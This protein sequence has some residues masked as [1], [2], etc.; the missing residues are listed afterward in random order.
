MT[1]WMRARER[2]PSR[3]TVAFAKTSDAPVILSHGQLTPDVRRHPR[4]RDPEHAQL[5]AA[6]GGVIGM[7]PSGFGNDTFDDFVEGTL[8]MVGLVGGNALRLLRKV[9]G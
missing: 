3:R 5:V 4:L 1:D 2:L 6:T 9:A 7:W 8:D